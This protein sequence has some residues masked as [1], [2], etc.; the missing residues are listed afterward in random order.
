M[1]R[2]AQRRCGTDG[3]CLHV[4]QTSGRGLGTLTQSG[5]GTAPAVLYIV[6]PTKLEVMRFGLRGVD[7]NLD[8]FVQN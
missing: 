2:G 3:G 6:S 8:W 1:I 7:A 4:D 5:V